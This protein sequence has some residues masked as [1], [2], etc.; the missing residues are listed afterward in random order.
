MN[1]NLLLLGGGLLLYDSGSQ[2]GMILSPRGHWPCLE[3]FLEMVVGEGATGIYELRP[4][5]LPNILQGTRESQ[6]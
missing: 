3:T 6:Q 1:F 2:P 4:G 5:M